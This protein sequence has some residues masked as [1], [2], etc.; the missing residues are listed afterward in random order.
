MRRLFPILIVLTLAVPLWAQ[1]G[2]ITTDSVTSDDAAIA[3]RIR[4]IK[5]ELTGYDDVTVTVNSGIVTLRGETLNAA[6]ATRIEDLAARVDGVVAV[7]N[8]LSETTDVTE[9]LVPAVDR[10]SDRVEKAIAFLPL[11]AISLA[12]GVAVSAVG[13]ALARLQLPWNHLAPNAFIADIFR[14]AIRIAGVITGIVLALDLLGATALLSTFLGAAGI[15]GLALSFAVRDTVEN[16]IAS[17][18]LS[19]RQPFQPNDTV[20]IEGDTGK[21]VRL[22]SRATVLMSFDGNQIRI[23]NSTVF[24]ARIVNYTRNPERRFTFAIGLSYQADLAEARRIAK[25]TQTDLPFTLRAPAPAAWIEDMG[26]FSVTMTCAAWIDQ[27]DADF[28]SARSEAMR[29]VKLAIEN[30]HMAAPEPTYRIITQAEP[31]APSAPRPAPPNMAEVEREEDTALESIV[32]A[33]R[34]DADATDLLS[35]T[36]VQ[37]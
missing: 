15:I 9:R 7:R 32:D 37:E 13:F 8:E 35:E 17:I 30:A 4:D 10:I 18:M 14:V 16:F 21:V 24:K 26:D 1:D 31:P 33:E 20:E 11:M 2:A 28:A 36:A 3:T 25:A 23:P 6:S 19:I 34:L 27:S 22:T 29:M 12:I 5:S